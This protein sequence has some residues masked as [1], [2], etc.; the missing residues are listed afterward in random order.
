MQ[1]FTVVSGPIATNC[2][3]IFDDASKNGVIIDAP[4]DVYEH[5]QKI[6]DKNSINISAILLT[7]SHWDHT[8]D[9]AELHRMTGA[10]VYI[11]K[12][13]EYRLLDP[14]EHSVM[15]LPFELE[16]FTA[17]KYY[18][19]KEILNC[20]KINLEVRFTPGHTEGGISVVILSEKVVFTGDTLFHSSIGRT[21]LPG[22]NTELLIES[23]N[24]QL[25]TLDDDFIVYSGHGDKTTIGN[26]RRLNPFLNFSSII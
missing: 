23:I 8:G 26:E 1:L 11:H 20:G 3:L 21:D 24:N 17:Q 5:L 25:L 2:Y 12:N 15:L 19:N 16:P 14:M 13:D 18:T 7:H 22:G 9:T 6:I 10:P 4:L